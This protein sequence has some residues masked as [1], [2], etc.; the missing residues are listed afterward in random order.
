M[1]TPLCPPL[2]IGCFLFGSVLRWATCPLSE[3]P[4]KRAG[5]ALLRLRSNFRRNTDPEGPGT[6]AGKSEPVSLAGREVEKGWRGGGGWSR[7]GG[8]RLA[9]PCEG[10]WVM[11]VKAPP[12]S[13]GLGQI[14]QVSPGSRLPSVTS[15]HTSFSG[16]KLGAHLSFSAQ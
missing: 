13:L 1:H 7:W 6:L 2:R 3:A 12:E 8:H 14:H 4:Q 16:K 15:E 9:S 5:P 10:R 11:G